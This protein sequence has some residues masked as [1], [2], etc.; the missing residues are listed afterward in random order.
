MAAV[1][2]A[3]VVATAIAATTAAVAAASAAT[4]TG[5][6]VDK[7]LNLFLSC[8]VH[9]EYL[10]LE[11]KAHACVGMVEVDGHG[12]LLNLY[13]EAVHALT[14]GIDKGNHVAGIDLL[15]VKLAID[16]EDVLVYI[17]NVLLVAVAIGLVL[18]EGEVEGVALLEV[19]ELLLECF[20]GEAQTGGK[21]E[22][23]LGGSLLYEFFHAVEYGVHIVCYDN[24]LARIDFCHILFVFI[25]FIQFLIAKV[26]FFL[27]LQFY[28]HQLID[29]LH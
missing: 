3:V 9:A 23:M 20:E 11:S 16:A 17:D 1:A 12:A 28:W 4:L 21:L 22:G 27:G 19:V 14:L 18:G 7:C 15:V 25:Y 13:H 8:I 6:D 24:G 29:F 10:T 5:D 2:T 26:S